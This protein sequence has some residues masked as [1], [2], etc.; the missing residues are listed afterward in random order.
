M[1]FS[2]SGALDESKQGARDV[3]ASVRFRYRTQEG[4][5]E[6][7]EPTLL[8]QSRQKGQHRSSCY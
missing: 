2:L 7:T 6:K 5:K 1:E 8:S 3:K 4:R